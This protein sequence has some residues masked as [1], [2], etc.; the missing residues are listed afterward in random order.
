MYCSYSL[1]TLVVCC[2]PQLLQ[3]TSDLDGAHHQMES[4]VDQFSVFQQQSSEQLERLQADVDALH[5]ELKTHGR[6]KELLEQTSEEQ[7]AELVRLRLAVSELELQKESLLFQSSSN[8]ST[9]SSLQ[10]QVSLAGLLQA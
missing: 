1:Y 3:V 5:S 2:T 10:S 8:D 4:D 7:R 6:E 9:I